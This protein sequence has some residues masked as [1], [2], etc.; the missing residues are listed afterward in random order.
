MTTTYDPATLPGRRFSRRC[1][2]SSAALVLH[3]ATSTEL[4][5]AAATIDPESLDRGNERS[6]WTRTRT[7]NFVFSCGNGGSAS[8]AN[9]LQCDHL[10]G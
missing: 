9:H 6:S 3:G 7:A 5:Q 8:V 10:K 4:A 2:Y 1:H